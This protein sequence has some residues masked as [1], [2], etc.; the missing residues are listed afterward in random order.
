VRKT[1]VALAIDF[2]GFSTL[3]LTSA[4]NWL[5]QKLA[6]LAKKAPRNPQKTGKP[7][8]TVR[9]YEGV[10][11]KI[12]LLIE[13]DNLGP[14]DI[15]P[16]ERQLSQR[17]KV[18]RHSLREAIRVLQEQ[19][20]LAARQG[21]G[22]YIQAASQADLVRAL[23]F[24][25]KGSTRK[26]FDLFQMREMLE[27]QIAG[28][29]AKFATK[30][31]L[32]IIKGYATLVEQTE[33]FLEGQKHDQAFHEAIAAATGNELLFNVLRE[34]NKSMLPTATSPV[35]RHRRDQISN[36]GHKRIVAAIEAKDSIAATE[37]MRLHIS[38][39]KSEVI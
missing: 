23:G 17:F 38:E 1:F 13:Q 34:I 14:G 31:Q 2:C 39:I 12:R 33:D 24:S 5:G 15:L 29:A 20:V 4:K 30:E 32:D 6:K 36:H 8:P 10:V 18:S 3:K 26:L 28:L 7:A 11:A 19:G 22:N 25:T 27:P 35:E 16:P 37:A 21:S 9:A